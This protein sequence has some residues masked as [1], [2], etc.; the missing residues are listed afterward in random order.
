MFIILFILIFWGV[1]CRPVP[2]KNIINNIF[3]YHFQHLVSMALILL[4][5]QIKIPHR[6]PDEFLMKKVISEQLSL[7]HFIYFLQK[8]TATSTLGMHTQKTQIH[9]QTVST[10]CCMFPL[11]SWDA[12]VCI[13]NPTQPK[14]AAAAAGEEK[15]STNPDPFGGAQETICIMLP[16]GRQPARTYKRWRPRRR[17]LIIQVPIGKRART[18]LNSLSRNHELSKRSLYYARAS[19]LLYSIM[20]Q[21]IHTQRV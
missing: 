3:Q 5:E 1:S 18:Q 4:G 11:V 15:R 20:R 17:H 2:L 19:P 12:R 10:R 13:V 7:S 9:Q 21:L 14:L 16:A 8:A 6:F